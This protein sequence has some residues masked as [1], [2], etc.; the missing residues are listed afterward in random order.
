MI[1]FTRTASIDN[2]NTEAVL[3]WAVRVSTYINDKLGTDVTVHLNVTGSLRQVHWSETYESLTEFDEMFAN[4][5]T[6]E[7]YQALI[8]ENLEN[9]YVGATEL[10]DHLYRSVP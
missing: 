7:G 4:L 6:D 10:V 9:G 8:A 1:T 2:P 5:N 3:D